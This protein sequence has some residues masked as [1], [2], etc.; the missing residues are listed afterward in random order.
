V[1]R[2]REALGRNGFVMSI[3]HYTR[4]TGRPVGRPRV[5]TRGFI[6]APDAES[7]LAQAEEVALSA[8]SAK[9]GTAPAE[10]EKQIQAALSKFLYQETKNRPIVIPTVI[11]T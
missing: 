7:L 1:M 11:E 3:V 2:E 6:F 10:I 4:R 5:I 9:P 8:A